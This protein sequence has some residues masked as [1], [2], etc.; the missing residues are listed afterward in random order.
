MRP[1]YT[2]GTRVLRWVGC[3]PQRP[4]GQWLSSR[5]KYYYLLRRDRV[6]MLYWVPWD[7]GFYQTVEYH[8]D[9]L[10]D[11][12]VT[13]PLRERKLSMKKLEA[14]GL[15]G[16]PARPASSSSVLLGKLPVTREYLCATVYDD[17]VTCRQPSA[18]RITTR[19]MLWFL[20]LTDPDRQARLLA[21]DHSLD[22]ALL[23]METLL[24]TP[25]CP[26]QTDPYARDLPVK[27]R[28]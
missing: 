15:K 9:N 26:W 23:L 25:E 8:A 22:K 11:P 28:K 27:G 17:A 18:L 1:L 10:V 14:I 21:S 19:D 5:P 20:T 4:S 3:G 7:G 13:M 6:L 24:G 16:A 12:I 2:R